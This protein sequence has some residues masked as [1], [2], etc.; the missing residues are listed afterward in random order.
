MSFILRILASSLGR[1]ALG[2][3]VA[4]LIGWAAIAWHNHKE[5]LKEEGRIEC[6]QEINQ[7]TMVALEGALA[8][9]RSANATLRASLAAAAA[10]NQQ[11]LER[12]NELET[13]VTGLEKAMAEQ[14]RTDETYRAW[15]DTGLPDGV[16]GR[17]REA[18]RSEADRTD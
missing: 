18:A 5:G 4:A 16:A 11:A 9:E 6:V 14:R 8:D 13:Q 17:L 2:A 15:S 10:V 7:A 3:L 12:R 1:W